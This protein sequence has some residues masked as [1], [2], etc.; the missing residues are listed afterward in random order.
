MIE[1]GVALEE[2]IQ[3]G[4]DPNRTENVL[5]RNRSIAQGVGKKGGGGVKKQC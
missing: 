2:S 3:W 5:L 1:L 4:E